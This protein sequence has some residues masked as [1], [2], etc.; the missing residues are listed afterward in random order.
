[1]FPNVPSEGDPVAILR[2]PATIRARA[3]RL[4]ALGKAGDLA[5]FTVE[6]KKMDE[7]AQYVA[8]VIRA[9][10][11]ALDIPYHSRWRHFSVGGIDRW[12]HLQK[13][14]GLDSDPA[15]RAR[16]A[17]DLAVVS[18][19]LDAGAG[20]DWRYTEK[21]STVITGRSEGL[22][23]A[24][25]QMF[26]SGTFSD[27]LDLPCR[28]DAATLARLE[29]RS[30]GEGFQ[31]SDANPLEG[32]AGRIR[33]LKGL[34]SALKALPEVFGIHPARP[35]HIYDYLTEGG[36]DEIRAADILALILE[37]FSGIW[38]GRIDFYGQNLGDVWRHSKLSYS[39]STANLMPFHKLSQWLTYSLLE[40]FEEAGVK[41][42]GLDELTGLAEYRNGGLFLDG[43][44][45]ALRDPAAAD[46][47]HQPGDEIIVEWRGLTLALLDEL[48]VPVAKAL[49]LDPAS[50]PLARLLEGGS[51]AAGRK[52]AYAR[53]PS[54]QPPLI[55][56]SD[57]TVF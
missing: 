32:L 30:L 37:C 1:M 55:I 42:T 53:S 14:L 3:Q 52:L 11:P 33:L 57:G 6:M 17:I 50:F 31:V 4:L 49:G 8:G 18:V 10:Y 16:V 38:P 22:A 13:E 15:E 25:F 21:N 12:A 43:G 19:L 7:L 36:K 26:R 34:S 51:W 2:D 47:P 35:G 44:V 48:R 46:Q 29:T 20:P 23:L 28:A 45:L 56:I 5:H 39:N 9:Q 40:P 54:G 41:I 27:D 24:S